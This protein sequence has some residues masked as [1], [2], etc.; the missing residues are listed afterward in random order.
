MS[1]NL[2]R[3][4]GEIEKHTK[5]LQQASPYQEQYEE[6]L[7]K[8]VPPIIS[9]P[10]EVMSDV[11]SEENL[12][13]RK[14]EEEEDKA[15]KKAQEQEQLAREEKELK[16]NAQ[17]REAVTKELGVGVVEKSDDASEGKDL[18]PDHMPVENMPPE[19]QEEFSKEK[20]VYK[21]GNVYDF[22]D[23]LITH[24]D[25]FE[26]WQT[27]AVDSISKAVQSIAAGCKCKKAQREKMVE[28]YYVQFIEQNK[29][30]AL[31][32]KLKNIAKVKKIIFSSN[33]KTFLES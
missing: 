13:S 12:E 18:Y 5:E 19:I 14:E 32:P 3:L 20:D 6:E 21:F 11:F 33:G 17:V 7:F 2:R 9:E 24:R 28:D 26:D 23:F 4:L 15:F 25:K 8:E 30:S 22:R 1:A 29:E 31:I 16:E 27:E 10:V